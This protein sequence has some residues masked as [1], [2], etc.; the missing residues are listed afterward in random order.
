MLAIMG[1]VCHGWVTTS[2]HGALGAINQERGNQRS[3][4]SAPDLHTLSGFLRAHWARRGA[5]ELLCHAAR[6]FK[7]SQGRREEAHCHAPPKISGSVWHVPTDFPPF[8]T[9]EHRPHSRFVLW[10]NTTTLTFPNTTM[11][12]IFSSIFSVTVSLHLRFLLV[13]VPANQ[14]TVLWV[15]GMTFFFWV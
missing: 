7:D 12:C 8:S 10:T 5:F 14:M 4:T 15:S 2:V 13:K 9:S 11:I 6:C 1:A 3:D